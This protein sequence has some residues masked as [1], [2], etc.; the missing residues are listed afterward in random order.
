[1]KRAIFASDVRRLGGVVTVQ[2][3]RSRI[4]PDTRFRVSHVSGGGDVAF[5]SSPIADQ[6]LADA[7]A[8]VLAEFVGA[9]VDRH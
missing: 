1:M 3:V 5:Q 9:S 7:A 4:E 2:Q 8:F 6:D